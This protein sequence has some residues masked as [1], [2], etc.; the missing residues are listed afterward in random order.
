MQLLTC[1]RCATYMDSYEPMGGKAHLIGSVRAAKL[2]DG[3][4]STPGQ[5]YCEVD[6]PL[7]VLGIGRGM[8]A[9]AS[10]CSI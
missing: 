5:L 8:K 9:D 2:L 3:F 10:A 6:A 7:L 1:A 4:V